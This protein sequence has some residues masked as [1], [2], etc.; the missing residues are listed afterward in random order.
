[1]TYARYSA[2]DEGDWA[3][4]SVLEEGAMAYIGGLDVPVGLLMKLDTDA[5]C[6]DDGFACGA[7]VVM[8]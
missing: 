6:D 5:P 2:C 4:G 8:A 3:E 7:A 1:V